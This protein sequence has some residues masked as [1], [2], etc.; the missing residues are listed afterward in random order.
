MGTFVDLNK[1]LKGK[2]N[3]VSVHPLSIDTMNRSYIH[4][5]L[6]LSVDTL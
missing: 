4:I 6:Y 2:R 3:K 5:Y 1:L